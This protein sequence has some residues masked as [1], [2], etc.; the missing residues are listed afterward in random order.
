MIDL[1][2]GLAGFYKMEAV[3]A[4]TGKKRVLADWFPNLITDFGLNALGSEVKDRLVVCSVGSGTTAPS[5]S[6]TALSSPVALTDTTKDGSD[7]VGA[8]AEPPYYGW[9]RT[10]KRFDIGVAAGNLSEV[11]MSS[12][13][14]TN[15]IVADPLFSRAL[16]LDGNGDPTTITVLSDEY[17]DVTYELRVYAPATDLVQTITD[18]ETGVTHTVTTRAA[19]VTSVG[20]GLATG[21]PALSSWGTFNIGLGNFQLNGVGSSSSTSP[22]GLPRVYNGDIGPVTALPSGSVIGS[23]TTQTYS[24]SNAAYSNNSLERTAT[25][26]TNLDYANASNRSLVFA[27]RGGGIWQSQI[28]PAITKTSTDLLTFGVKITWG[29]YDP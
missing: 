2:L 11:G 10:T 9:R 17:L 27:F 8:S 26:V 14:S 23:S 28:D 19:N 13:E 20:A 1:K 3:S 16:I 21:I 7:I 6:D 15:P 5:N 22:A 24:I 29:R 25:I 12:R 18:A 4:R